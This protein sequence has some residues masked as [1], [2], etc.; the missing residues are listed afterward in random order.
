MFSL[1]KNE[2]FDNIL[3]MISEQNTEKVSHS[4][5]IEKALNSLKLTMKNW[6]TDIGMYSIIKYDKQA[7]G[8]TQEEIEYIEATVK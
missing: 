6:K 8:L 3:R 5:E 1:K 7:F 4:S 2:G